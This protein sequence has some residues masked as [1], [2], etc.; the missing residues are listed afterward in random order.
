MKPGGLGPG[1][2]GMMMFQQ[3]VDEK[4]GSRESS[5]DHGS[6]SSLERRVKGQDIWQC[7]VG[8]RGNGSREESSSESKAFVSSDRCNF[9]FR[10]DRVRLTLHQIIFVF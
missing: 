1:D 5:R 4:R 10:A 2:V 9:R 8:S 7:M 3:G 6:L